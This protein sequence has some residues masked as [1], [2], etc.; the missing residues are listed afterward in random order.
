MK[1][2]RA[3]TLLEIMVVVFLIGLIGSVVG[4]NMKGSLE[5][6]KVFKTE[7]AKE[8][9]EDL[10]NLQI[11]QGYPVSDVESDPGKY[12]QNAGHSKP[13]NL[14]KD[15]WGQP[16]EIYTVRGE[17]RVRSQKLKN[18]NEKKKRK[19]LTK[20]FEAEEDYEEEE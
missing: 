14:L 12:L 20:T 13:K 15:G 7:Q 6:G 10:L 3:F 4:Y 1:K 19:G 16:F 17:I 8:Q 18:Y 5:E 11:A 9:I 2:K